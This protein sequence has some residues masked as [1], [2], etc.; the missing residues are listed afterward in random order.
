MTWNDVM[1]SD[2]ITYCAPVL[3]EHPFYN[4]VCWNNTVWESLPLCQNFTIT[5]CTANELISRVAIVIV[6]AIVRCKVWP[7]TRQLIAFIIT[8][9]KIWAA[10][11]TSMAADTKVTRYAS[12]KFTR[13]YL[14][15]VSLVNIKINGNL[16]LK[17]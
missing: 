17:V 1:F 7:Y 8:Y 9:V 15:L 16:F 5:R 11:T 13:N 10:L 14:Y 12:T 2:F 6:Y 4:T 3:Y